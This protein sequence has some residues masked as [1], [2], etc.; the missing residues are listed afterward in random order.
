MA[1]SL[2]FSLPI[3]VLLPLLPPC[4]AGAPQVHASNCSSLTSLA[5]LSLRPLPCQEWLTLFVV[6]GCS[7]DSHHPCPCNFTICLS[8]KIKALDQNP[9]C[10]Q[11]SPSSLSSPLPSGQSWSSLRPGQFS[12]PGL[13][14]SPPISQ[15]SMSPSIPS[16]LSHTTGFFPKAVKLALGSPR[17]ITDKQK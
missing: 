4:L 10:S 9:H 17:L 16:S 1:R 15:G 13:E 11:T 3:G 14:A 5:L 6:F 7:S 8:Q 2:I 12:Y